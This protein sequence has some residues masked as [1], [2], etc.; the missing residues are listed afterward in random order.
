MEKKEYQTLVKAIETQEL[1]DAARKTEEG[2][3]IALPCGNTHY[4]MEG[5]GKACV[6]VPGYA[7]PYYL[8]DQV[9]DALLKEGYKVLRYDLLGRGLSERV[10]TDYT[11]ELFARQLQELTEALLGDEAFYLLGTSM[12]GT[13]TTTFAEEHPEKVEKLVLLAPAG[14]DNFK[15]PFY[16]KLAKKPLLGDLIFV[17]AG[18]KLSMNG[19]AKELLHMDEAAHDDYMRRFAISAKYKGLGR[20]LLS[21]LRHTILETEH[22]TENYL[23]FAA[24]HIPTLVLWGTL[25]ATMPYYQMERM[26]E[27]LPEAKFVTFEGSGHI[28]L[29]DEGDKTMAE[30]LPFL[31]G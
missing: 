7:T 24:C 8:Y 15:A 2:S 26:K 16:M 12:G 17:V 27:V 6:M 30:V 14:M 9:Y 3:F 4:Q 25:D 1:N 10:K 13:I 20:C 22:D 31:K 11:P 28:F 21:S 23:K 18:V 5:E 19:C 29:Y